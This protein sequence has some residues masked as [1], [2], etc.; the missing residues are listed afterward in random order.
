MKVMA[1]WDY[2]CAGWFFNIKNQPIRLPYK[3]M[4]EFVD[5][6]F[7]GNELYIEVKVTEKVSDESVIVTFVPTKLC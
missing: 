5:E 6:D 3:V 7:T 4:K 2:E 1:Y